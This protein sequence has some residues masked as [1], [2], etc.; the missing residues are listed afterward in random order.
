MLQSTLRIIDPPKLRN[1]V[2]T[3]ALTERR[4]VQL[5]ETKLVFSW[6]E[7]FDHY[8]QFV[9]QGLEGTIIKHPDAL[10]RDGT[11]KEQVKLK[12]EVDVDLEIVGFTEGKGKNEKLFGSI[13]CRSSD[14]LLEVNASGFSDNL[15]ESI[16]DCKDKLYGTIMTV[17]SNNIMPPTSSNPYYSLFLPRFVEFRDDK[18]EADSLQQIQDQF[19]SAMGK[20]R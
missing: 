2:S 19:D 9:E 20:T 12:L 6:D 17:K 5:I 7:A 3:Q 14:G 11:S 1:Q 15:R 13:T 18:T 10:W 8:L 4:D 16:F